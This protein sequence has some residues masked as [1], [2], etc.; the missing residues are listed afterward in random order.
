M[1]DPDYLNIDPDV[2]LKGSERKKGSS[3]YEKWHWGYKPSHVM[4]WNDE[5]MPRLLIECGKL[6][7]LHLRAPRDDSSRH[8]RRRRDAMIEFSKN[9][10][11]FAHIAYDPDHPYE[12]LYLLIP[13]SQ[14]KTLKEHFWDNNPMPARNLNDLAQIAGGKHS[15]K[16]DYPDVMCKPLGVLTGVVYYTAKQGDSLKEGGS[17]YIHKV[18]EIS[19]KYPFLC[20][21]KKGRLWLSGGNYTSPPP[22]I[23]D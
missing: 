11:P 23:T 22:G 3:E 13:P 14:R 16:R 6:V 18:G 5:D 17:F 8:P 21:D 4:D 2:N 12:R 10:S 9:V 7:R 20:I 1:K 15:R 19:H